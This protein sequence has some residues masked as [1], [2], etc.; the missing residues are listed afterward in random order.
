V[1]IGLH[2]VRGWPVTVMPGWPTIL[3]EVHQ[4]FLDDPLWAPNLKGRTATW[5]MIGRTD[6]SI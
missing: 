2:H 3:A 5:L 4:V 1:P 6:W